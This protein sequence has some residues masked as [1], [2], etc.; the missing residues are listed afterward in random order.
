MQQRPDYGRKY[1]KE[2]DT[3]QTGQQEQNFGY[4]RNRGG[5]MRYNQN[6][7]HSQQRGWPERNMG[8]AE[9]SMEMFQE[10][11][12]RLVNHNMKLEKIIRMLN[13]PRY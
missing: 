1:G 13:Q 10:M 12:G 2:K 11:E 3:Q 6:Q 8:R 4:Q 9:V 7:M 5:N